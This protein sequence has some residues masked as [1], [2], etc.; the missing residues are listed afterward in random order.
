[1]ALTLGGHGQSAI[2]ATVSTIATASF[3]TQPTATSV[4]A[5]AVYW[6]P[7][8]SQTVTSVTDSTGSNTYTVAGSTYTDTNSGERVALY[9]AKNITTGASFTVTANMSGTCD[10]LVV[11]AAEIKGA[12]TASPLT[13]VLGGQYQAPTVTAG[14]DVVTTGNIGTP[15]EAGDFV[16][17]ATTGNG[18]PDTPAAGTGYTI[19]DSLPNNIHMTEYLV[20]GA[21]AAVTATW[22]YDNNSTHWVSA[23]AVFKAAGGA[24]TLDQEGFRW[25]EDNGSES[26]SSA[27][28]AQ[29]TNITAAAGA[30][31]RLRML[32]NATGDPATKQFKLQWKKSGGSWADVL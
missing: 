3:G 4:I 23:A 26:G 30:T 32:V 28:A 25:Y 24:A 7:S 11:Q 10:Q 29:D 31:K 17:G 6:I 19:I 16:F 5:V 13:S 9:Y 20:Q 12:D 22:S 15:S 2:G 21:A 27:S 8:T 1:M 14:T 18:N